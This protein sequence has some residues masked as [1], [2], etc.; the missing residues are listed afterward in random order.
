M[1]TIESLYADYSEWNARHGLNLGS[2]DEHLFDDALTPQQKIWLRL[3]I[4]RWNAAAQR[5]RA[6]I[7]EAIARR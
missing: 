7:Q 3:F 1:D 4:D 2:A 6:G 5:E